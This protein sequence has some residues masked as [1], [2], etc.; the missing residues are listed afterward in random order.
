MSSESKTQIRE[1]KNG[2]WFWIDKIIIQ[3]YVPK[4]GTIGFIV[5]SFLASLADSNQSCFP[6]QKYIAER[7]G[8]SRSTVNKNIKVLVKYG[9]I[10]KERKNRYH[11][12][13]SLIEIRCKEEETQMLHAGNSDVS[14]IDTNDNKRIKNNTNIDKGK[15]WAPKFKTF[16]EF[17]PRT[18]EELLAVDL[19][20]ALDDY[21]GLLLYISFAKKYPES[22]LRKILG[23]VKEIPQEKIKKSRG[24]L[25][26]YLVQRNN[27]K[28]LWS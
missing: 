1:L 11:Y 8:C 3:E 22:L 25:F 12:T 16:K 6:S 7:L 13:Y 24:A 28:L 14:Q 20:K 9:L 15:N 18:R 5:Y 17:K 21:K 2:K 23:Q 4:I 19:A 27:G 26:N 10:K